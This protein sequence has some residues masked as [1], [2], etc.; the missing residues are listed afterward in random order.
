MPRTLRHQLIRL[1]AT[2]QK[3]SDERAALLDVLARSPLSE[4]VVR[5][6]ILHALS[7]AYSSGGFDAMMKRAFEIE[8]GKGPFKPIENRAR[9]LSDLLRE[10]AR[11][12]K[13]PNTG[14]TL[15]LSSRELSRLH[16]YRDDL[17]RAV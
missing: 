1:A 15:D 6:R 9:W 3:G 7:E 4:R 2:L 8:A 17:R 14:V 5:G 10:V 13:F 12:G 16:Q 11:L